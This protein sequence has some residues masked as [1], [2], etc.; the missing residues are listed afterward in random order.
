MDKTS[1]YSACCSVC[2]CE[3]REFVGNIVRFGK[4]LLRDEGAALSQGQRVATRN[5]MGAAPRR[6]STQTPTTSQARASTS[7]LRNDS[8][9][10][11]AT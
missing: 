4:L 5:D 9:Q 3:A 10:T 7:D 6:R 1:V 8:Q 2:L 11:G